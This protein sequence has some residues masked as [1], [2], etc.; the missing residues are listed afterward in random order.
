MAGNGSTIDPS[1]RGE[2]SLAM[3]MSVVTVLHATAL[4]IASLRIYSR[5]ALVKSFG[6]DDGFMLGAV[7]CE[8]D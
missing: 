8:Q 5:I 6:W 4:L 1:L 3:L 2:S 7:V